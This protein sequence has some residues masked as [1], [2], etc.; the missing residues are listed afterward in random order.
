MAGPY[1]LPTLFN[2]SVSAVTA[3]NTVELGTRKFE[4]KCE[5]VYVYNAGNSQIPPRYLVTLSG[6]TGYSGTVSTVA[7]PYSRVCGVVVNATLTTGTYG[8]IAKDGVVD[9]ISSG[10]TAIVAGYPIIPG[11]DGKADAATGGTGTTGVGFCF[12]KALTATT[13]A[14][15]FLAYIV[16]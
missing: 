16:C 6:G 12:G 7:D 9:L 11:L 15:T 3:T 14:G 5:W 10:S 1:G 4:G 13:T 8:W 2:E